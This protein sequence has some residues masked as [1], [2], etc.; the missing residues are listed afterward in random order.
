MK[1]F[2]KGTGDTDVDVNTRF[3]EYYLLKTYGILK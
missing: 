2:I 1:R 3:I